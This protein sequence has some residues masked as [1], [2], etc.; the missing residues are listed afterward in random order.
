M[1]MLDLKFSIDKKSLYPVPWNRQ[2][3]HIFDLSTS[4]HYQQL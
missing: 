1:P 3:L 4:K 2:M